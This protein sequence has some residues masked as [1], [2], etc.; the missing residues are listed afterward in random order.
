MA[1]MVEGRGSGRFV[2]IAKTAMI[3]GGLVMMVAADFSI[4]D[5]ARRFLK[6][7][8]QKDSDAPDSIPVAYFRR[9]MKLVK[10]TSYCSRSF[11]SSTGANARENNGS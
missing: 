1:K 4:S 10:V 9:V 8:G 7:G 11:S 2:E 3:S 6:K 5:R